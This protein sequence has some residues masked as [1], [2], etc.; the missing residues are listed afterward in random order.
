MAGPLGLVF[1]HAND[2]DR[3]DRMLCLKFWRFFS[4]Y[5][6][7][8]VTSHDVDIN[9][10][11]C[12]SSPT[13]WDMASLGP[14][15]AATLNSPGSVFTVAWNS[16]WR[17]GRGSE[18]GVGNTQSECTPTPVFLKSGEV[19]DRIATV[20]SKRILARHGCTDRL[21]E[22]DQESID[23]EFVRNGSAS[24]GSWKG[25]T[26]GCGYDLVP[27]EKPCWTAGDAWGGKGNSDDPRKIGNATAPQERLDH[28]ALGSVDDTVVIAPDGS[29]VAA[30][31][32]DYN[33]P[34]LWPV[35]GGQRPPYCPS[36]GV[37]TSLSGPDCQKC[38]A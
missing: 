4:L 33:E 37:G 38:G 16:R 21:A 28:G 31:D 14:Q 24:T 22:V 34:D 27:R 25:G 29:E 7:L 11:S 17:M 20:D 23:V 6:P 10:E 36:A 8:G 30:I 13:S 1:V 5:I 12:C 26:G 18:R 32:G 3:G 2:G 19:Q 35:M 15:K 9:D